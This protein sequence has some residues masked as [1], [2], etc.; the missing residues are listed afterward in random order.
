[1]NPGGRREVQK[2]EIKINRQKEK[3]TL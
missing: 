3:K 2:N 1:M